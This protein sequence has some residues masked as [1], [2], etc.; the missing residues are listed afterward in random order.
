MGATW[1]GACD[2]VAASAA[3]CPVAMIRQPISVSIG[4]HHRLHRH[5]YA[6]SYPPSLTSIP[7]HKLLLRFETTLAQSV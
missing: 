2:W 6:T 3:A 4:R 1:A 5:P 7:A